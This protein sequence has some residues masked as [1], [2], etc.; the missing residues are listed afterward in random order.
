MNAMNGRPG[1]NSAVGGSFPAQTAAL[2]T[3]LII[4]MTAC[5]GQVNTQIRDAAV[6]DSAAGSCVPPERACA[7]TCTNTNLDPSNC[8]SCGT[9]CPA[10]HSCFEGTCRSPTSIQQSC[11]ASVVP[12]CGLVDVPGGTVIL[13]GDS[14]AQNG[15]IA[16]QGVRVRSFVI[17]Q[18]PVTVARFRRYWEAGHPGIDGA[19]V[20][21]RSGEDGSV[22]VPWTGPV[23]EPRSGSFFCNWRTANDRR[24]INCVNWATAQAFCVWDGARLPTEA[25]WEYVARSSDGSLFPW[26]GSTFMPSAVCSSYRQGVQT[27]CDVDDSAFD[28]GASRL[29]VRHLIGNVWEWTADNFSE[30]SQSGLMGACSNRA[31]LINPVCTGSMG[32]S[33]YRVVRGGGFGSMLPELRSAARERFEASV[34]GDQSGF[35]CARDQR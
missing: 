14:A 27:S 4:D 28:A 13:G 5:G 15:V 16:Q 35:R 32:M 20:T 34:P 22:L 26:G 3:F 33:R 30:Y 2:L 17:D 31:S 8:G 12:G 24:P 1:H 10:G 9:T 7:G 6:A 29:G 21:Y 11:A 23:T 25:E 18:Y 19:G